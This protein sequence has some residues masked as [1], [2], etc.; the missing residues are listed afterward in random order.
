M[1]ELIRIGAKSAKPLVTNAGVLQNW[2]R[3]HLVRYGDAMHG[4]DTYR[5]AARSQKD[6]LVGGG[7]E[8]ITAVRR[9]ELD[10][11]RLNVAV[12]VHLQDF[13]RSGYRVRAG[14][15]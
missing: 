7:S 3:L 13:L 5:Q 12:E 10:A 11:R 14:I 8:N 6:L 15:L 2:G 1:S 4:E 9:T